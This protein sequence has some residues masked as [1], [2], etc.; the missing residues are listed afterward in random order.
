MLSLETNSVIPGDIL[1]RYSIAEPCLK[2]QILRHMLEAN[3]EA[4]QDN[5]YTFF[6]RVEG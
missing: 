4:V 6:I 2:F 3:P 5:K 1:P